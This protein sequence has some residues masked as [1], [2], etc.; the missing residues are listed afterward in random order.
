MMTTD[1]PI[2]WPDDIEYLKQPIY[3]I[4]V[5]E[6]QIKALHTPT[7]ASLEWPRINDISNENNVRISHV[8]DENH[9]ANGQNGL[10]ATK[11]LPPSTVIILYNGKIHTNEEND[12]DAESD[13]DLSIDRDLGL[14]IDANKMGNEARFIND[15]RGIRACA[16]AEFRDCWVKTITTWEHRIGIFVLPPAKGGKRSSGI[17]KGE[18]IVVNYGRNFWKARKDAYER[19]EVDT[20]RTGNLNHDV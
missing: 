1:R 11:D 8:D 9:P 2:N 14:S 12:T 19:A 5:N 18:E 3:S 16:N 7:R 13:Y 20:L 6:K 10:F 15:Y 17:R 4:L